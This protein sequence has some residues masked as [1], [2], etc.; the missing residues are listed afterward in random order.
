VIVGDQDA[1]S[2]P[3]PGIALADA[4]RGSRL[5]TIEGGGHFPDARDPIL[6]N[7]LIRDFVASSHPGFGRRTA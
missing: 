3:G 7:L 2:G 5:V 6:T 1:I 4:V